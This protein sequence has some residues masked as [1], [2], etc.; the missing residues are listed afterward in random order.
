MKGY[1]VIWIPGLDHAGIA[2]Q[3]VVEKYLYK[4]KGYTKT[5][6]GKEQ[7]L[8]LIWEWKNEKGNVIKNQLRLLGSSVDWS[9]EYFTISKVVNYINFLILIM[10]INVK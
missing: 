1:P 9:K 5:D 3:V 6:I 8:S 10:L 4:T 2:T 7:F